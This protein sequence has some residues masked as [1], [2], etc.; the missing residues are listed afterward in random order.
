[1][2]AIDR[3]SREPFSIEP[4]ATLGADVVRLARL[5]TAVHMGLAAGVCGGRAARKE[6]PGAVAAAGAERRAEVRR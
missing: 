5:A 6:C 2:R 1:M 3:P 4:R